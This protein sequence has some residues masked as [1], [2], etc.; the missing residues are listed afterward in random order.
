M[1]AIFVSPYQILLIPRHFLG[2]LWLTTVCDI[3][4][5]FVIAQEIYSPCWW[6][7][8]DNCA[9]FLL[10]FEHVHC[11]HSNARSV[12]SWLFCVQQVLRPREKKL[13]LGMLLK[14]ELSSFS[15]RR[16]TSTLLIVPHCV[17]RNVSISVYLLTVQTNCSHL[18]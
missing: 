10:V 5:I 4:D 11:C 17:S 18:K 7:C 8:C 1:F 2:F 14:F 6:Q 15:M 16:I 12:L 13:G 3:T 9:K